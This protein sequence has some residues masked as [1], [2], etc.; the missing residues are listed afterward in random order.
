[1]VEPQRPSSISSITRIN[2]LAG[3]LFRCCGQV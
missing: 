1:M 2:D 3:D